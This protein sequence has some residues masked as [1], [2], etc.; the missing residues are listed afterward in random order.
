MILLTSDLFIPADLDVVD[1]DDFI[2][3]SFMLEITH[4]NG[5]HHLAFVTVFIG[6]RGNFFLGHSIFTPFDFA[7]FSKLNFTASMRPTTRLKTS[8]KS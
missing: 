7:E 1:D 3:P 4:S 2:V 8:F 5:K 6:R